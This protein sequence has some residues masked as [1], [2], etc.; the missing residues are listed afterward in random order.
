MTLPEF[1]RTRL[2]QRLLAPGDASALVVPNGDDAAVLRIP[3]NLVV[4]TDA[5]VEGVD[6]LGWAPW[7]SAGHKALAV[8]LSDLAAMGAEPVGY[9]NALCLPRTFSDENLEDLARGMA[10]LGVGCVGGDFSRIDG[11]V[12][13][14]ITAL[15]TVGPGQ[16]LTRRGA[17]AGDGVYVSGMVGAA[18]AGLK[19]L[20]D[21]QP[22]TNDDVRCAVEAQLRP[23]PR[24]ALGRALRG[25]ATAVSDTHLTL[26]TN[27]EV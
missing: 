25:V 7:H 20:M 6:F 21:A 23:T 13:I 16:A 3:G 10:G 12:V 4:T 18:A 24:L 5:L 17:R 11:P 27:R 2:L 22:V 19:V 9:L 1:E 26:P 14:T 15:G 8:N